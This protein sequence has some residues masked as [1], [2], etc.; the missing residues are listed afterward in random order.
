[1]NNALKQVLTNDDDQPKQTAV[2][3]PIE[4]ITSKRNRKK[5]SSQSKE[6]Q[7][8]T[9]APSPDFTSPVFKPRKHDL[10]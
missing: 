6:A 4:K 2:I 8:I 7:A 1:M 3:I 5:S 9:P 10:L